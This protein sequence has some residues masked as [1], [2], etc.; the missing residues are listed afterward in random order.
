MKAQPMH[1][2]WS[3]HGRW[4]Y[5]GGN[6]T[7]PQPHPG[8]NTKEKQHTLT[9]SQHH[10]STTTPWKHHQRAP[11]IMDALWG[12]YEVIFISWEPH[13]HLWKCVH[14]PGLNSLSGEQRSK[15]VA[16]RVIPTY[17]QDSDSKRTHEKA[18]TKT[19]GRV[20]G[21]PAPFAPL[22]THNISNLSFPQRFF[23]PLG[24]RVNWWWIREPA[25]RREYSLCASSR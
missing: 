5:H 1:V 21:S 2:P 8:N 16:G 10:E 17:Y 7:A 13:V 20:Q 23:L 4:K 6:T 9:P 22:S 12:H 11:T 14:H 25:C 3:L 15:T 19:T 24:K 18:D